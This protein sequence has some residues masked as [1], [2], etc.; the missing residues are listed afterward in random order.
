M[1]KKWKWASMAPPDRCTST[2]EQFVAM[3]F[4]EV[5]IKRVLLALEERTGHTPEIVVLPKEEDKGKDK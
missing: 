2:D 4:D 3:R 1:M 5:I